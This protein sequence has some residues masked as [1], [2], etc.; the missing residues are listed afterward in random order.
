[1]PQ[2]LTCRRCG[3][4]HG[5]TAVAITYVPAGRSGYLKRPNQSQRFQLSPQSKDPNR[6]VG[7]QSR[8]SGAFPLSSSRS[9][10]MPLRTS[11]AF[12]YIISHRMDAGQAGCGGEIEESSVLLHDGRL[13]GDIRNIRKQL[14]VGPYSPHAVVPAR[15]LQLRRRALP[16]RPGLRPAR[17]TVGLQT[18]NGGAGPSRA[19]RVRPAP[20]PAQARCRACSAPPETPPP[21]ARNHRGSPCHHSIRCNHAS[22]RGRIVA[23]EWVPATVA[24]IIVRAVTIRCVEGGIAPAGAVAIPAIVSAS[25]RASNAHKPAVGIPVSSAVTATAKAAS[26]SP[27]SE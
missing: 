18:R 25:V 13:V 15:G 6:V 27:A 14:K 5:T 9:T 12:T 8:S 16:R 20:Q 3:E 7:S 17:P 23:V 11:V 24:A 4:Y 26:D 2:R 10:R 1:M 21:A 19:A 22:H